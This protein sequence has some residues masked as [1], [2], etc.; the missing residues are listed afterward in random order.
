MIVWVVCCVV[1][2]FD[3]ECIVVLVECSFV[4]EIDIYLKLGFVSYVDIGSYMDMDVVMFVCS[5]VV[6]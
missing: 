5:V 2:L 4:F 3:V 6:L 1:V